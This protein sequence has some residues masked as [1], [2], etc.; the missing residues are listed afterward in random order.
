MPA[1]K[2]V[3]VA[4]LYNRLEIWEEASWKKYKPPK[5]QHAEALGQ[6]GFKSQILKKYANRTRS[7]LAQQ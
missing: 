5:K 3:V 6:L 1:L 2:A 7:V 4:G